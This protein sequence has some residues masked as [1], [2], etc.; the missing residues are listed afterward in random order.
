M[1]LAGGGTLIHVVPLPSDPAPITKCTLSASPPSGGGWEPDD[2]DAVRMRCADWGSDWAGRDDRRPKV[3]IPAP[4]R[5]L[6]VACRIS[7]LG[8]GEQPIHDRQQ[9]TDRAGQGEARRAP[10]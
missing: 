3:V 5:W 7:D 1:L 9:G 4:S 8:P 2:G 6:H 10:G